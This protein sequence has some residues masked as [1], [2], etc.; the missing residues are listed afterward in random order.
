MPFPVVFNR[1]HF[2]LNVSK[3][4][5]PQSFV[6]KRQT[7]ERELQFLTECSSSIF[8][9]VSYL[10][11]HRY[12]STHHAIRSTRSLAYTHTLTHPPTLLFCTPSRK[13]MLTRRPMACCFARRRLWRIW[14]S[15][16]YS[17]TSVSLYLHTCTHMYVCA[18]YL[19]RCE[20]TIW[21]LI[22]EPLQHMR[23]RFSLDNEAKICVV[24]F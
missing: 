12:S 11:C 1:D 13:L 2:I 14:I 21:S 8:S 22:S 19:A 15:P 6:R 3:P 10:V 5:L 24:G 20:Q 18:T 9:F 17:L 4:H 23:V 7:E 16:N